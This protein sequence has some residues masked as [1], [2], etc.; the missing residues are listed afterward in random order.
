MT[1]IRKIIV[2]LRDSD[3]I[4]KKICRPVPPDGVGK[5]NGLITTIAY[6]L[7]HI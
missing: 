6:M 4:V 7:K 3:I 1:V 2:C 5:L